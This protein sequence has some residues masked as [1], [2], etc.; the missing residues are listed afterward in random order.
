VEQLLEEA[1]AGT[2]SLFCGR[3]EAMISD[4]AATPLRAEIKCLSPGCCYI[5][6]DGFRIGELKTLQQC[7][8]NPYTP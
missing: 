3:G 7:E 8:A 4:C 2:V 5:T 6:E 1:P